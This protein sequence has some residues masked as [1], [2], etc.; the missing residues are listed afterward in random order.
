MK[1]LS[2]WQLRVGCE[3]AVPF[4]CGRTRFIIDDTGLNRQPEHFH[5]QQTSNY[6]LFASDC[7]LVVSKKVSLFLKRKWI[8]FFIR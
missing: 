8:S 1:Y 4:G 5:Q 6:P 3:S 7:L 2:L